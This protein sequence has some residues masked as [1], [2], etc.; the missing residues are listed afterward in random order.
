MLFTGL[1]GTDEV[2]ASS[3]LYTLPEGRLLIDAG[4][5]PG[6]LG[7]AAL[8][9]F[10]LLEDGGP[11]AILITHAHLD[12]IGALPLVSSQ[13][14]G[15]PLLMTTP[16]AR[17]LLEGLSD[18]LKIGQS[19]G[20]PLFNARMMKACLER[21]RVV[22]VGERLTLEGKKGTF[23]L[24]LR[25]AGHLLGAVSALIHSPGSRGGSGAT[26]YHSGDF[27]NIA[28]ST[29]PPA[30]KPPL[31]LSVDAVVSEST[32]GDTNLPSR[33]EQIR[34]FVA[35]LRGTL[36]GGG[37]ILIPTFALGRAQEVI[38]VLLS[39][40]VGGQLPTVPIYL[41][42]L[43]RA[44]TRTYEEL[45]EHL[46]AALQNQVRNAGLPPFLRAP[47]SEVLTDA[48]RQSL[49]SSGE[50]CIVL[51]S[52]GMLHAGR[53]PYY[54]RALLPDPRNALYIVGIR[55]PSL[56]V[57]GCSSSSVEER[58]NSPRQEEKGK[59]CRWLRR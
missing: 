36:E 26:V 34:S 55:T 45:L 46:P 29:T 33:K 18:S 50:A 9:D 21:I 51:A 31:P 42:G 52:S 17:L 28:G 48:Q 25:E 19:Q 59:W 23:T 39:H 3:Y 32:Y 15:A 54:A 2:G 41:D 24:E 5:R 40:M 44:M 10:A 13:Y 11:D 35:G 47:V 14:P 4:V 53:S 20:Q 22:P 8:P 38:A 7:A 27:S 6:V 12:H 30:F 1:G 49:V 56:R 16:T 58:W 37:K 57:V 43:V